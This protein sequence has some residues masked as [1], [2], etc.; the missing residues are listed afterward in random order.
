MSRR[1]RKSVSA[2][3]LTID[4]HAINLFILLGAT[5]QACPLNSAGD[6]YP[7]PALLAMGRSA[8]EKD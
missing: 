6:G 3:E 7:L 1:S 5:L 2:S 8:T 4:V